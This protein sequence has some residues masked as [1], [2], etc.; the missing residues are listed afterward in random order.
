MKVTGRHV[1]WANISL[2]YKRDLSDWM[3]LCAKCHDRYDR[4]Y[5][6]GKASQMFERNA[7]GGLGARR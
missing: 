7:N 5:G 4:Q 6:W 2:L 3:V 1:E